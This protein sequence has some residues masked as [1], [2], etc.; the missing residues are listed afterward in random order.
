MRAILAAVIAV[1]LLTPVPIAGQASAWTPSRTP[2]GQPDLQGVWLNNDATPLER[3]R[4]L[5]GRSQL[6]DAEVGE[7]RR[8][9]AVLLADN[10]NDFA[11]GDA[12]FL[13]VLS[14]VA[15]YKSRNS[16][17]GTSEMI[18]REFDNRT[19]LIVDP[20]DGRIPWTTAGKRRYDADVA[21]G[22]AT[23][24]VGPE[25][26]TNVIRCLTYGVPRL[27]V[28]NATAAGSLGYYLILQAPGY[29]VLMYEAIHE[30]RIIPL[31][32]R[33]HLPESIRQWSGDSRGRWEGNTL[34]VETT[35]FSAKG[36]VMGSG[37]HLSLV[38]RFT[39]VA[40]DRIDYEM[41]LAD[42]TTWAKP[43]T[44]GI[45]LKQRQ[46]TLYEYACHEGNVAVM[47]GVLSGARAAEM[48]AAATTGTSGQSAAPSTAP[49]LDFEFF[50]T[51]VQPIFLAKRPGHARCISC[52]T[53]GTPLRLQ[54]L[55]PGSTTW[56]DEQ[57]RKN[58]EAVQRVAVGSTRSLLL[59][60][61]L[62]E[63]AGGDF[64]HSGGKHW[65]SQDDP[66]WQ[67]LKAWVTR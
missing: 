60:H 36:N 21:A 22:Q 27:G 18:E 43:W 33:P 57:S 19:S 40:A 8:R 39:R 16:T 7:F 42:P 64:F 20:P 1:E 6:T 52:H 2:D 15:R 62:A 65:D 55:S 48:A 44:V 29:V 38:E 23:A 56:N 61:P 35:N 41:T 31:D 46:E 53:S 17:A 4:E 67:I 51:K 28:N 9:A 24:P 47:H 10:D 63:Q 66:E 58:F 3:P 11:A 37:E 32:G 25:D 30:A 45:R 26:L 12:L 54:P 59:R 50:K 14:N 13:A 5:A 34:V 49:A